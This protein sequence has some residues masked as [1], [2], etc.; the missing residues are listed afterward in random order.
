MAQASRTPRINK[1]GIHI[2]PTPHE[3]VRK[4][5]LESH[6][7]V[8][9]EKGKLFGALSNI[10]L[11][12]DVIVWF[13]HGIVSHSHFSTEHG[14]CWLCQVSS[15]EGF[16]SATKF[17]LFRVRPLRHRS[18]GQFALCSPLRDG[19]QVL[20]HGRR[21]QWHGSIPK[22]WHIEQLRSISTG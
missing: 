15:L 20:Q 6:G 13:A 17:A 21:G 18:R 16:I 9:V 3:R 2:Q 7:Y 14:S 12:S 19:L 4:P 5:I 1:V 10:D 22:L 8:Y 11:R